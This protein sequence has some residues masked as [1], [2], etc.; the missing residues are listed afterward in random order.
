M[1][2]SHYSHWRVINCVPQT[3]LELNTVLLN[4]PS[5]G[6]AGVSHHPRLIT[7]YF[8]FRK[9]IFLPV[10]FYLRIKQRFRA[11]VCEPSPLSWGKWVPC[12]RT[13]W[14][15]AEF[16]RWDTHSA[17]ARQGPNTGSRLSS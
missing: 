7:S 17:Q 12:Y 16:P 3:N 4:L 13:R 5:V 11:L 15:R 10:S 9:K 8:A 6:I 14:P 1:T 2:K